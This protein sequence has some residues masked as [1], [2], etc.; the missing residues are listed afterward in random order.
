MKSPLIPPLPISGFWLTVLLAAVYLIAGKFGLMLA[1]VH[2]SATA[3]WPPTGITMAAFLVLGYRAWPGVFIGAFLVNILTG[4]TVA[5]T[6]G[7]ATGNTLEGLLGAYWVNRFA[8]GRNAF[9]LPLDILKFAILAAIVST[10]VS[11]TLGVTS[12]CLGGFAAWAN[13]ESIWLAWWLGDAVGDLT[14]APLLVLWF[15]NP[16]VR[17]SRGQVLEAAILLL[18]LILIGQVVFGGL[19]P[20]ER[21]DYPLEFLC[22]PLLIWTAFRFGRRETATAIF[23]LSGIATWGTLGGYGPFAKGDESEALLLLQGFMGAMAL[24]ALFLA[25]VVAERRQAVEDLR[26]ANNELD[27]RVQHRTAALAKSVESLGAEI[28]ARRRAEE[29]LQH[30]EEHFRS[31]IEN[32]SDIITIMNVDGTICYKSPSVERL[33]GYKPEELVGQIAFDFVHPDDRARVLSIFNEALLT[34]GEMHSAEYRFRHKAGAWHTLESIGKTI[35]VDSGKASIIV[36][37]RDITKR[38]HVETELRDSETKFRSVV[39]T[40]IDAIILADGVGN[41]IAWNKG[42]EVMFGYER[43]EVLGQALTLLMPERYR[44]RHV[45]GLERLHAT[46]ESKVIGRVIELQGLRKDGNEFPLELS[47]T[48]WKTERGTFYTSIVRDLTE[49]KRIEAALAEERALLARRVEERTAALRVANAELAKAARL[50]DEFLA[51]M[52]HELRTPLNA[53]LGLSEALQDQIYGALNPKQL[54]ALLGIEESGRHLLDLIN[55]ILDLSKIEAGKME[56]EISPVPVDS[57]C[58][59]SLRIINQIAKGKQLK[60]TST[61]DSAVM[62]VRADGRR[63]KQ[64]L[65]NLLSNAVKFTPEDGAIGLEVN[66][67]VKQGMV[68]FAVWDTGIGISQKDMEQL[69]QPFVQL[70]GTLSRPYPGTGL[71]L[72]LV[73]RMVEL[74]GGSITVQ[75]ELGKGSR[76]TVSLPWQEA[77]APSPNANPEGSITRGHPDTHPAFP[78]AVSPVSTAQAA[79]LLAESNSRCVAAAKIHDTSPSSEMA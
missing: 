69:F 30:S 28:S 53:I 37:S 48:M 61:F 16:R 3:V 77:L 50:K 76:F 11:A 32:A 59:A 72:A 63:L 56:L 19:F 21:K 64:I 20:A 45:R 2:P 42:A 31:L 51:S 18:C 38:K 12:L 25:A 35:W 52:S 66:G 73:H 4:G 41:I 70:N 40:A 62:L 22:V 15:A 74:H 67:D 34:P 39:K 54:K 68:H 23:V 49:R 46:G 14:V 26:R 55:D 8:G 47:L 7:I 58:Q 29:A 27:L 44:N 71:G 78:N 6:I 1:F 65:V 36:N 43:A 33:L 60:I 13:Y 57:V 5:T 17:W 24:L 10:M 79:I 9:A 75:S